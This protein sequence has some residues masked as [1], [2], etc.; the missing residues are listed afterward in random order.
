M[1][2]SYDSSSICHSECYRKGIM[3]KC[4]TII[5]VIFKTLLFLFLL[6]IKCYL[7]PTLCCKY[8]NLEALYISE[9]Y[10]VFGFKT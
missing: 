2:A 8:F 6:Y 4:Q 10:V 9:M 3:S 1:E 7:L 5:T